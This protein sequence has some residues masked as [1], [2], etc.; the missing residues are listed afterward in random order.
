MI[1]PSFGLTATERILP[2]LALDFTTASLDP[3]ITF[4][5]TTGASNPA[6]FINSSGYITAATNNQPRFDY[7]PLTLACRGLLI[8]ESRANLLTY[9]EAFDI[10]WPTKTNVSI[11]TPSVSNPANG[12]TSDALVE[13]GSFAPHQITRTVSLTAVSH[14]YSIFLKKGIRSWAFIGATTT[15]SV[16]AY[17]D[18]TNGVVGNV[19]S[20]FTATILPAPN[21][22]YRCSI[23]FTAT[24]ATWTMILGGASANGTRSYAGSNGSEALYM[25]GVQLEAGSFT[26][27][28]IPTTTAALTRNADVAVM[29]GT[30]FS[31]WWT[32][33]TGGVLTNAQ[34]ITVGG[35]C[36]WLQFDDNTVNNIIALRGNTTNPE[37]YIKATTDQAQIDAGTIAANTSYRLTGAWSTNNCAA[38]INGALPVTD[39][40]A[41]I[42]T[43]TQAR[44]GCD[45]TNYLNGWLAKISYWPQRIT[46]AEV[47]AFSK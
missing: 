1:T 24:A 19:D 30:N 32:A 22:F 36:P 13:N 6:T 18:L 40:S 7:N 34:Q 43:A 4:T 5:R 20:G 27:S 14:T 47:Q 31:S 28:Y 35:T 39:S 38:A 46:D 26:T 10:G 8:E 15:T 3:R 16:G 42:P 25:Y 17:F 9:S 29:T 44:L 33:T 12:S 11:T 41:N 21:G 37:L 2:R 23:T 45:G